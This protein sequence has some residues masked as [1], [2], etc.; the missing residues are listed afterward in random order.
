LDNF[1]WFKALENVD[2]KIKQLRAVEAQCGAEWKLP[3]ADSLTLLHDTRKDRNIILSH[4]MYRFKLH[5][6]TPPIPI[7]ESG[8]K[9]VY[10]HF[11]Q[12][13]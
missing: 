6:N 8:S 13:F 9:P 11:H 1:K 4:F 10:V 3:S 5:P 2:S 7:P 12:P